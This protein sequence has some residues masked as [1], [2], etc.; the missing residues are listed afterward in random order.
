[1]KSTIRI[2]KGFN[3][4]EDLS[5]EFHTVSTKDT[6]NLPL[7]LGSGNLKGLYSLQIYHYT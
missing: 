3:L 7:N 4:I 5:T 1:M 2:R 6:V